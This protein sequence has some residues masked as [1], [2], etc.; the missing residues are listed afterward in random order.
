MLPFFKRLLSKEAFPGKIENLSI[1]RAM[2]LG[3]LVREQIVVIG[4]GKMGRALVECWLRQG[5]ETKRLLVVEPFPTEELV[6]FTTDASIRLVESLTSV[7]PSSV[8]F[9]AVKPQ[10]ADQMLPHLGRL[11]GNRTLLI[12]IM[13]GKTIARISERIDRNVAIVRAMPNLPA[14]IGKGITAAIDNNCLST[15]QRELASAL[16]AATGTVTWIEDEKFMDAI[17]AVSGS[18]PA[19]V[20]LLAESLA[21]AGAAAGLP[22]DLADLL[23]RETV[24]GSGELLNET[25]LA[26]QQLRENVTSPG[27]T[28]AAA[29]EVLRSDVG[30]GPLLE[31][32]VKAATQRSR[33][34]AD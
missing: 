6:K 11:I 4:A 30:F 28:T 9:V 2:P 19:Y 23:A 33:E 13:A 7:A 29:L 34:L 21:R 20:F 25:P 27:G 10:I 24:A 18:G 17:T 22:K 31:K 3:N 16:L 12:S 32:A 14:T 8:L 15:E 1:Q 5:L 26:P